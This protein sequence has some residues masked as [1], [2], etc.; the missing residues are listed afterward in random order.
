[1]VEE[2][3]IRSLHRSREEIILK[4]AEKGGITSSSWFLKGTTAK[5]IKCQA[6]PDG[7]LARMLDRNLNPANTKERTKVVEEGDAPATASLS[8]SDP[9][10]KAECRFQD[11]S[12]LVDPKQD[13][14]L[15][16]CIYEICCK[17]CKD[18]VHQDQALGKVTKDPGGQD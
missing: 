9:Y 3:A 1:M 2:G 15:M 18:P 4:K 16:G 10:R 7:A 17:S 12:C 14:S 6:T 13:C 11:K 8:R 5:V